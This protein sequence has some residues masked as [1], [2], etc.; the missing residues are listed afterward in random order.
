MLREERAVSLRYDPSS[1]VLAVECAGN[2]PA[3]GATQVG[4]LLD[5]R[6]HLVGVDI[7]ADPARLVVML[8]RHE[9]VD[10]VTHAAA[11]I[12]GRTIR[13]AGARAAARAHERNPYF[14]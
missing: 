13:V 14:G 1:D 11:Q 3:S 7:G 8:G 2:L 5:A 12:D 4:L 10:R 9:D 6:G